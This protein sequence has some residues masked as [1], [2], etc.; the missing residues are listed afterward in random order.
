MF[1]NFPILP[2]WWL[3]RR[4]IRKKKRPLFLNN[5]HH[6]FGLQV[7]TVRK[8]RGSQGG[9]DV[10]LPRCHLFPYFILR[11][12]CSDEG[13]EGLEGAQWGYNRYTLKST[14]WHVLC[15][16]FYI[17]C[18]YFKLHICVQCSCSQLKKG[19]TLQTRWL[20]NA[21]H[22]KKSLRCLAFHCRLEIRDR[23]VGK[24]TAEPENGEGKISK[25]ESVFME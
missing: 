22:L 4:R 11:R 10:S 6:G 24:Y 19:C 8:N 20:I 2:V 17:F 18:I 16:E 25:V 1:N 9:N 13:R 23:V 7:C 15:A 14:S 5:R 3:C 21:F 12:T